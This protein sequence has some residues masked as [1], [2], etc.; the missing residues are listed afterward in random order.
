[1]L[2]KNN[3]MIKKKSDLGL[4]I[5]DVQEYFLENL[6]PDDYIRLIRGLQDMVSVSALNDYPVMVVEDIVG[7]HTHD[8]IRSSLA[9]VQKQKTVDKLYDDAFVND[10][11]Y[12]VIED[13]GIDRVIVSGLYAPA[14]V[15]STVKGA[16]KRGLHTIVIDQ[17]VAD[18]KNS[19]WKG[20]VSHWFENNTEYHETIIDFLESEGKP[21]PSFLR[22]QY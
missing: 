12:E 6:S 3:Q 11:N 21:I 16:Q 7:S 10:S 17:L 14:C 18:R 9:F 5:V 19:S 22:R 2:L 20:Q 13:W 4:V 1:V 8:Y 15:L